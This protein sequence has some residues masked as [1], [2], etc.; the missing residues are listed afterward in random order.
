MIIYS[1]W[2]DRAFLGMFFNCIP[3]GFCRGHFSR[4]LSKAQFLHLHVISTVKLDTV[5]RKMSTPYIIIYIDQNV[6]LS[7]NY[8]KYV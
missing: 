6:A 7:M 2:K 5:Q 1:L 4:N 8:R 3:I